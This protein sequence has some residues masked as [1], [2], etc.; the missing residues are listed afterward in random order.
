MPIHFYTAD[1]PNTIREKSS[2]RQ[3]LLESVSNELRRVG[4]IS[5]IQCSNTFLL[6]INQQYLKH[7]YYTDV[8]TFPIDNLKGVSGEVYISTEQARIQA[9]EHAHSY[10]LELQLLIIHGVLHLCG[11]SDK[12]KSQKLRMR[13][14]EKLYLDSRPE[15]LLLVSRETHGK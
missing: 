12:T 4:N 5:I 13:Q 8:I 10:Q 9:S 11:Y 7:D 14:L 15:K 6:E 1:V 3:W 2:L